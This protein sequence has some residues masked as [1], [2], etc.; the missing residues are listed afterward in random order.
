M[1]LVLLD[2]IADGGQGD[3]QGRQ[4]LLTVDHQPA[5]E[6]ARAERDRTGREHDR[7][8]EVPGAALLVLE[9]LRLGKQVHPDLPELGH[10]PRVRPLVQRHLELLG[11]L[12]HRDQIDF[13]RS[14]AGTPVDGRHSGAGTHDRGLGLAM[15][16][17]E[18]GPRRCFHGPDGR[19]QSR[20]LHRRFPITF[21]K[22]ATNRTGQNRRAM[23]LRLVNVIAG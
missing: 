5:A 9:P 21:T 19:I 2:V 13:V 4:A 17:A 14:H 22:R 11:A 12:H 18:Y 20:H 16:A 15:S 10:S 8:D 6:A 1:R 7:P 23:V 3:H